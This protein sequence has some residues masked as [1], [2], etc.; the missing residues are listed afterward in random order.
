M[1]E[2]NPNHIQKEETLPAVNAA[3]SAAPWCCSSHALSMCGSRP[4]SLPYRNSVLLPCKVPDPLGEW[5]ICLRSHR[6]LQCFYPRCSMHRPTGY[7]V[8]PFIFL[9]GTAPIGLATLRLG[10]WLH[11]LFVTV[12]LQWG[13]MSVEASWRPW[14]PYNQQ[15]FAATQACALGSCLC[16]EPFRRLVGQKAQNEKA[17]CLE[18][19][20]GT[21]SGSHDIFQSDSLL[22]CFP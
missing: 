20:G 8:P 14:E 12:L 5:W 3:H 19:L 1:W 13:Q 22:T 4:T 21:E 6:P 10:L 9:Q 7:A 11:H 17:A 15:R 18:G 16:E 2:E